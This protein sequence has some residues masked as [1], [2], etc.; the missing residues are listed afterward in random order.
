MK[1][2]NPSDAG[3][4]PDTHSELEKKVELLTR[5]LSEA[6]EQ[7]TGMPVMDFLAVRRLRTEHVL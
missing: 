3:G 2:A 4:R 5:A 7:Q 1:D 6:L